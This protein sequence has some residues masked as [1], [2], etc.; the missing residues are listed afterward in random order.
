[1]RN[2]F[3][4]AVLVVAVMLA[5]CSSVPMV[6]VSRASTEHAAGKAVNKE[7]VRAAIL[8][9]G[10]ALGWRIQDE[11]PDAL[12][13]AFQSGSRSAVI[14]ISYSAATFDVDYRSSVNLN[15]KDSLISDAYN[16]WIVK[17]YRRI[18]AEL[19]AS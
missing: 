17:L 6:S 7:Q 18:Q 2:H 16:E 9:A 11:S 4:V 15:E 12:V 13:G 1:M 3:K 10:T 5:G 19:A 14:A 8:R